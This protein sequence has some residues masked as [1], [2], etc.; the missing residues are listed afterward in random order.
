MSACATDCRNYTLSTAK[1]HT[2]HAP[3]M[4]RD[5]AIGVLHERTYQV[6]NGK[7]RQSDQR[8]VFDTGRK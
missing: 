8:Q 4:Y 6:V 7:Q 1:T 2:S 3:Y 5:A